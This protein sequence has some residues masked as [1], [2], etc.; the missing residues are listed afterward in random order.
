VRYMKRILFS[1]LLGVSCA[2]IAFAQSAPETGPQAGDPAPAFTMKGSDGK[3]YSLADLKGKTVVLAWFPKAFTGGCTQQCKS[4]K[5]SGA[6]I[7]EFNNVA[8]FAASVD[9]A[10]TN[11]KFAESLET[12]FPILSDPDKTA[13]KAYGVVT[14]ERPVAFRWTYYIGPDGKILYVDKKVNVATAAQDTAARLAELK[15]P[16]KTM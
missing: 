12:D 15:T 10:D 1:S 16:K 3:T 11:K 8:Y 7:R 5:E 6:L 13:A 14:A 9:D 2:A 4:L